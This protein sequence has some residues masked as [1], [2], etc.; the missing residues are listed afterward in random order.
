MKRNLANKIS[1]ETIPMSFGEW[2]MN[3]A[4]VHPNNR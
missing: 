2:L 1:L 3:Q 4:Q